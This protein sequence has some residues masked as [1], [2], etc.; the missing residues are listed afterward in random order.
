MESY[1]VGTRSADPEAYEEK[2]KAGEV[3]SLS[4]RSTLV[5]LVEPVQKEDAGPLLEEKWS[6]FYEVGEGLCKAKS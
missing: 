5:R 4:S 1:L 6:L 3:C 2:S